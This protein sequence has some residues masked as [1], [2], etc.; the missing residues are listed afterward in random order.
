MPGSRGASRGV[1]SLTSASA[2]AGPPAVGEGA[3]RGSPDARIPAL[4]IDRR[5]A[6]PNR[7]VTRVGTA[8][9][10]VI[11]ADTSPKMRDSPVRFTTTRSTWR[12]GSAGKVVGGACPYFT[13][14]SG[15][16]SSTVAAPDPSATAPP[17]S[18][19]A[20]TASSL[21]SR[22]NAR[23]V[24]P[25]GS[26]PRLSTTSGD[27][28]APVLVT[29]A[30]AAVIELAALAGI[31]PAGA[32]VTP[33]SAGKAGQCAAVPTAAGAGNDPSMRWA[34]ASDSAVAP[35][36]ASVA[37]PSTS[38]PSGSTVS[39]SSRRTN[40]RGSI[41][42]P[43]Q[44]AAGVPSR[45]FR[46]STTRTVKKSRCRLTPDGSAGKVTVSPR[47]PV[48][49]SPMSKAFR[50]SSG[51]PADTADLAIVAVRS[52][53]EKSP[54]DTGVRPVRLVAA[55]GWPAPSI[56]RTR[57]SAVAASPVIIDA[58]G[59]L[60]SNGSDV[61][62]SCS[63]CCAFMIARNAEATA[64]ASIGWPV[65]SWKDMAPPTRV[66][67][68]STAPSVS[69]PAASTMWAGIGRA[70]W[71]SARPGRAPAA[72]SSTVA[73]SRARRRYCWGCSEMTLAELETA[74]PVA[75]RRKT[76]ASWAT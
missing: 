61:A 65:V 57:T 15:S 38:F 68:A 21:K 33:P 55:A 40:G 8:A 23:T 1:P 11:G 25:A 50:T 6:A 52:V 56:S 2:A 31:E 22:L 27:G 35:V 51:K 3:V 73:Y 53:I 36:R 4:Q 48:V 63:G 71:P 74:A 76:P 67:P 54:A 75:S 59:G 70:G 34:T 10:P 46:S 41:F 7:F 39:G 45:Y 72:S 37:A 47:R 62:R 14:P 9:V 44:A 5:T 49:A 28:V 18:P 43:S 66:S 42:V 12:T 24:A 64:A 30:A 19:R 60:A 29:N 13:S 58:S 69:P 16:A 17:P 20:S 32:A 26:P